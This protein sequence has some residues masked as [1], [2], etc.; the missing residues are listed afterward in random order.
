M[1]GSAVY[2]RD[3]DKIGSVDEIFYDEQTGKPEWIGI[4]TGF[5]GTKRVL[6]P[7]VGARATDEGINVR[8][9]KDQVKDSPDI[10][11]DEISE[12]TELALYSHY[13][14]E[15][16]KRRSD[17]LLP[18]G[19]RETSRG[20]RRDMYRRTRRRPSPVAR[21][22]FTLARSAWREAASVFGNGSR[23]SRSTFRSSC[24]KRRSRLSA[25]RSTGRSPGRSS[26]RTRWRSPS[27]RSGPWWKSAP[28]RRSA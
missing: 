26:V 23:R 18:T 5:F 3:G 19:E 10:D 11:S 14:L 20:G 8:Y 1:R 24:G 12:E 7:V 15:A 16:S 17:T 2:D 4:G 22:S 25:S 27:A 21:K 28:S 13:G 9:S 6:V